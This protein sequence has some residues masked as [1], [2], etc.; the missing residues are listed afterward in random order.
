MTADL[1]PIRAR[2]TPDDESRSCWDCGQN[3]PCEGATLLA[4]V[5]ELEAALR[6]IWDMPTPKDANEEVLLIRLIVRAVLGEGK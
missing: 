4:R 2:H 3:W 1:D 5:D 6:E